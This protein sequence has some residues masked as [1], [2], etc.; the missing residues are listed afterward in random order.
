MREFIE[1]RITTN[2]Y[3]FNRLHK[4]RLE[5]KGLIR[6]TLCPYHRGENDDRRWYGTIFSAKRYNEGFNFFDGDL[7]HPSWKL[8][9]KNPKQWMDKGNIKKIK[10]RKTWRSE[11]GYEEYIEFV[12]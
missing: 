9:S 2:R 6:C 4:S 8:T 11:D 3:V 12:F 10:S 1:Y 5:Q 7:R